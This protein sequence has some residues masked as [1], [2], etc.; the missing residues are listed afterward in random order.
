MIMHKYEKSC[1][2]QA[3]KEGHI[4]GAM[5]DIKL[6][7]LRIASNLISRTSLTDAEIAEILELYKDIVIEWRAKH[8]GHRAIDVEE[9]Y[10]E[11][12]KEK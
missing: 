7:V 9:F 11:I 1:C 10:E 3:Y 2:Q 6:R 4:D 8:D 12:E 5:R